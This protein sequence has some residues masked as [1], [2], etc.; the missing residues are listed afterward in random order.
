[1]NEIQTEEKDI[2]ENEIDKNLINIIN[3][4][5]IIEKSDKYLKE[6]YEKLSE[7]N[8]KVFKDKILK[9]LSDDAKGSLDLITFPDL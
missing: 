2:L 3:E 1:L 5:L 7:E 6:Y 8:K 9:N 4:K